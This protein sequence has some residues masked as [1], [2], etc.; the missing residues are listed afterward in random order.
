MSCVGRPKMAGD[1]DRLGRI[2]LEVMG[3]QIGLNNNRDPWVLYQ[4]V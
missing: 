1:H 2:M 3:G 4:Y